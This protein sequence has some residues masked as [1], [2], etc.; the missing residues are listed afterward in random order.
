M[1]VCNLAAV[2]RVA[3]KKEIAL[4]SE[5]RKLKVDIET[6][7]RIPECLRLAHLLGSAFKTGQSSS[8]A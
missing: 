6:G 8:R 7:Y 3:F 4:A 1:I 5:W 2:Q